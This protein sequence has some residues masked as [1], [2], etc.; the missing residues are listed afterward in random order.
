MKQFLET[1]ERIKNISVKDSKGLD[2]I[3]NFMIE[4]QD[5]IHLR[6]MTDLYSSAISSSVAGAATGAVIALAASGSLSI[7]AGSL[8][9]AGTALSL[10]MVGT[11]ASIAGSTVLASLSATPLAAI[12]APALLFTGFSASTK[13]DENLEKAQAM[14]AEAKKEVE[15]MKVAETMC[16]AI[17]KRAQ[18]YDEL[19]RNLETMF[20]ESVHRLQKLLQKKDKE[21]YKNNY[22]S[23]DFSD[24]EL[25]VIAVT[26][27]LAGAVK[28]II[29]TPILTD[30]GKITDDSLEVYN[31]TVEKL[32]TFT[33]LIEHS[34]SF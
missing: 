34:S 30:D 12:V 3:S 31:N 26:R 25:E 14:M 9:L 10:G 4:Q 6:E 18:M 29:D 11:A 23:K 33:T 20:S 8:S 5:A 21:G 13:A 32:P 2:E 16:E 7:V 17:G 27:A 24:K 15:K 19:L 28:S 1:Y 22:N